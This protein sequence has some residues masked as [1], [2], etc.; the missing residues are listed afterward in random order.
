ME[1]GGDMRGPSFCR[2]LGREGWAIQVDSGYWVNLVG[3][4]KI[5]GVGK[6]TAPR[7]ETFGGRRHFK[8]RCHKRHSFS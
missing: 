5:S 3:L 7:F 2:L 8:R 4:D 6:A 1:G